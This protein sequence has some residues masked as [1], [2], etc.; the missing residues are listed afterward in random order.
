MA[1]EEKNGKEGEDNGEDNGEESKGSK[2][3]LI[4]GLVGGLIVGGAA[5]FGITTMFFGGDG[6]VVDEPEPE[7]EPVPDVPAIYIS[8]QRLPASLLDA[9]GNLLG[10]LFLDLSLEVASAEDRDWV[11]SRMPLVRDA[12]L[13]SISA[14]GVMKP[15]SLTDLDHKGLPER[16][17]EVANKSLQ[18]EVITNILVTNALR[19]AK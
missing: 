14:D 4:A 1:D 7:P 19:T 5:T 18:R 3:L 9:K 8:I 12:F 2:K 13:R 11:Q 10:Y 17:R 16:L 15:G 6:T